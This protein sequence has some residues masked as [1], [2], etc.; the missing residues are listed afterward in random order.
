MLPSAETRGAEQT[1]Q[2]SDTEVT[3]VAATNSRP[4]WEA[5]EGMGAAR[6]ALYRLRA[7]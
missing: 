5:A 2:C 3:E 6:V 7:G 4:R 1:R